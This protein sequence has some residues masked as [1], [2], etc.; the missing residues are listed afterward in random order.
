MSLALIQRMPISLVL[1]QLFHGITDVNWS[2]YSSEHL[3]KEGRKIDAI[4]AYR[5]LTGAGLRESKDTIERYWLSG[6]V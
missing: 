2:G 4:K 3:I 5:A 1:S 6:L